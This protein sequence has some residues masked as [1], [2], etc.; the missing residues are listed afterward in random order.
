MLSKAFEGQLQRYRHEA[1]QGLVERQAAWAEVETVIGPMVGPHGLMIMFQMDLGRTASLRGRRRQCSLYL[2]GNP[3]IATEIVNHDLRAAMLV[4]FRVEV[5]ADE[6]GA[7]ITYDLPSSS[8]ATLGNAEIDV[9]G[10]QLGDKIAAVIAA[11]D[12]QVPFGDGPF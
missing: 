1:G 6:D 12:V 10:G 4:P 5:F 11:L 9:I 8:L 7:A 2:V 3:L